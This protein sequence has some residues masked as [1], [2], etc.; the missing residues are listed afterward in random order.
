MAIF[1]A[2]LKI[3]WIF[4]DDSETVFLLISFSFCTQNG[5][6][7]MGFGSECRRVNPIALRT[8]KTP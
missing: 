1:L 8:A 6:T 3:R 4:E 5:Q 7:S 2:E